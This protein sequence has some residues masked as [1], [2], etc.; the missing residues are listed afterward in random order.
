MSQGYIDVFQWY[1]TVKH[2]DDFNTPKSGDAG[3]ID[4]IFGFFRPVLQPYQPK[5]LKGHIVFR[6]ENCGRLTLVDSNY[7]S[8]D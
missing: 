6:V 5:P 2:I 8:S 3:E 1:C 7:D 4:K